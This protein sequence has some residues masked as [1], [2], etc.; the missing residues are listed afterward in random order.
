MAETR[1]VR[2]VGRTQVGTAVP[3][4][5]LPHRYRATRLRMAVRPMTA[6]A[7]S[8]CVLAGGTHAPDET[9]AVTAARRWSGRCQRGV[10]RSLTHPRVATHNATN[11]PGRP[12]ECNDVHMSICI[13]WPATAA[14]G[15]ACPLQLRV[16]DARPHRDSDSRYCLWAAGGLAQGGGTKFDAP[17]YTVEA[18]HAHLP[19][20]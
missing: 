13:E 5:T 20:Q 8:L 18:P 4:P 2:G 6:T 10:P 9:A 14:R 16:R 17:L 7:A 3:V 12:R 15:T 11:P 19:Q 1:G